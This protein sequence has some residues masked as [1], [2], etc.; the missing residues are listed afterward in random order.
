MIPLLFHEF[1]VVSK[2]AADRFYLYLM[3]QGDEE[4]GNEQSEL[5]QDIL[6]E[7]DWLEMTNWE[8]DKVKTMLKEAF[9]DRLPENR[10]KKELEE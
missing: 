3:T 4:F 9:G 5:L 8:K 2:C 6:I 10:I 7:Q 1:P